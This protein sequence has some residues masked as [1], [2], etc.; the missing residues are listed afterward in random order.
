M[1]AHSEWGWRLDDLQVINNTFI[2][3]KMFYSAA[4][5]M[6][7]L[8]DS[9]IDELDR[10]Q[11]KTMR[12]MT[13]QLK[14]SPIEAVRAD[15]GIQSMRTCVDRACLLSVEKAR[16]MPEGH[17]R[18]I[19]LESAVPKKKLDSK[20]QSW[21]S[22]GQELSAKLPEEADR[23]LPFQPSTKEP[24]C[25]DKE[26]ELHPEMPGVTSRDDDI[27]VKRDASMRRIDELRGD[28]VI[29]TDGSAEAGCVRGGSA[30]VITVGDAIHPEKIDVI[31]RRGASHTSSYEEE[32]QA[33]GDALAWTAENCGFGCR[34][35]ICTDSQSL[36][37]ALEEDS[38]GVD[39]LR[40]DINVCRADICIQ[41]VPG[42][43]KI[44]GN[45][46]ADEEA[47]LATEEEGPGRA[48]SIRGIKPVIN[49]I[50]ND[51]EIVHERTRQV[52]RG[53]SRAKD[54]EQIGN[55]S[56]ATLLRRLRTGHHFG[57]KTYQHCLNPNEDPTCPRC[58]EL[59]KT[60]LMPQPL[61]LDNVVHWLECPATA[62]ARMRT[63]GRVDVGVDILTTD[64]RGSLALARSTLRGAQWR[65]IPATQ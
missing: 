42:H 10:F 11:N 13:G 39:S 4:A 49:S 45:D 43:S 60:G 40:V 24:W 3:S 28:I 53:K 62:E 37:K 48:V 65:G 19:A 25:L 41:W 56:D 46:M 17:P 1:L 47:K 32:C 35:V 33:L 2:R 8:S 44:P 27:D 23:R 61:D 9:R 18:R 29:Y 59:T 50:I 52:Y 7:Y 22:R 63:I 54:K 26:I 20:R 16:R 31:R 30:A 51:G 21:F 6:P 14:S 5:W 38:E 34:V 57:F 55:R 64:P 12:T 58:K 15:C 36:C